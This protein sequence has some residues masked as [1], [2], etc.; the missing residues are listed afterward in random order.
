MTARVIS[1][2]VG[3]MAAVAVLLAS[4]GAQQRS[5]ER[6]EVER[7]AQT[8]VQR[9]FRAAGVEPRRVML[10]GTFHF[11]D[12]GLDAYKPTHQFDALSERRQKE[13]AEVVERL[14]AFKPDR[15]CVE[16]PYTRQDAV[17]KGFEAYVAGERA[18]R[19]N[20]IYQIGMRLAQ[21]LGHETVYA[22]DADG[23]WYEPRVDIMAYAREHGQE[24]MLRSPLDGPVGEYLAER[25]RA[26]DDN[27]LRETFLYMNSRPMIT[28]S[29]GIYLVNTFGVGEG[30]EYPGVDGF[31]SQ[32]YNR[33][34]KIFQNIRRISEPGE[35]VL[36]VIGAG[37]LPII[38]HA[39]ESS[40]EFEVVEVAEYLAND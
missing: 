4:A 27:H 25:D 10:L 14:A 40:P 18:D 24:A 19:P 15:V 6:A 20:E 2:A 37:H 16:F 5:S 29:H 1:G 26:I 39:A 12:A 28:A 11:K 8:D 30:E 32:W 31:V 9:V 7:Q 36:V 13:I 21:K 38:R 3:A 34:L 17:D 35:S 22:I 33:N 23:R